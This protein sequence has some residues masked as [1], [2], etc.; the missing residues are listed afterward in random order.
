MNAVAFAN[1]NTTCIQ[2]NE[3]LEHHFFTNFNNPF[4]KFVNIHDFPK[5]SKFV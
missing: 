4:L 5:S 1:E 2:N 3:K